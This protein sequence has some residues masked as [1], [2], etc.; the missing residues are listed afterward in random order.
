[1]STF[2]VYGAYAIGGGTIL[3]EANTGVAGKKDATGATLRAVKSIVR[4]ARPTQIARAR[5]SVD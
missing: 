5:R 3:V 1:M 4:R 2:R